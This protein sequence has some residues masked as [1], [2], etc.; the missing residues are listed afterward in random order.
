MVKKSNISWIDTSNKITTLEMD[1]KYIK[2]KLDN[3]SNDFKERNEWISE[4]L[5][6]HISKEDEQIDRIEKLIKERDNKIDEWM[7]N[8][9]KKFIKV[10]TVKVFFYAIWIFTS[11]VISVWQILQWYSHN[12]N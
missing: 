10:E 12:I 1:I 11:V 7:N 8:A 4:N 9:D 6:T 2:E 3:I 5:K